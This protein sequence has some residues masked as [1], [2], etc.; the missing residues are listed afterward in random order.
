MFGLGTIINVA[1]IVVGGIL[2]L[3]FGKVFK[4]SLRDILCKTCGVATIIL[5][6]SGAISDL[7][8]ASNNN[9]GN[10]TLLVVV[11][12]VLGAVVGDLIDFDGLIER[13]GNFLKEKTKSENDKN[14]TEGFVS[15]SVAVSVGAMA[16][17]GALEDGINH[18]ITILLTKTVL[19]FIIVMSLTSSMGK[20]CIFSAIPV[21]II[22]GLFT[23]LAVLIKPILTDM[24]L[25]N[26]SLIGSILIFCVGLN[27]VFGKKIK[28]ANL[29]PSIIFAIIIAYIPLGL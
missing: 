8:N 12:L 6:L 20:G 27:L 3:L 28:V 16:I 15:A 1:G 26:L 29:I 17:I 23:C 7:I 4:E 25:L 21:L 18:D 14:F 2:G 10:K 13:F 19:D 24:A 22:Q 5:G 9:L 11:C